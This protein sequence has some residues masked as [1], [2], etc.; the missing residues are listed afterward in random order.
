LAVWTEDEAGPF[1]TVPFAGNGWQAEGRPQRQPSEYIRNGTAKWLTLF[2]PQDGQVR[3]QGVRRCTNL[4]LHEWLK[5]ELSE[6]V[7][8]LPAP[9][10]SAEEANRLLWQRWQEG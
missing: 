9:T 4:V 7:A 5:R 3:V 2:H 1:Q 10:P 6:N 8:S